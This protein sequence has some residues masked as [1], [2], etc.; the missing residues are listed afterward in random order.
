MPRYKTRDL[1]T[2][3]VDAA[4]RRDARPENMAYTDTG[5]EVAPRCVPEWDDRGEPVPGTGCPLLECVDGP[6]L[7]LWRY[8]QRQQRIFELLDIVLEDGTRLT[9]AQVT[10]RLAITATPVNERTVFRMAAI[11]RERE[12][13]RAHKIVDFTLYAQDRKA[14]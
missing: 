11:W 3:Q 5:C 12:V 1:P 14:A 13:E 4:S 7:V 2:D 9:V 10:A 6:G 8:Q